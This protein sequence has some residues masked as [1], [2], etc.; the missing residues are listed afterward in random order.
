VEARVLGYGLHRAGHLGLRALRASGGRSPRPDLPFYEICVP[1]PLTAVAWV[2]AEARR[3][4]GRPLRCAGS[5]RAFA[6]AVPSSTTVSSPTP[7][8]CVR[9]VVIR[10]PLPALRPPRATLPALTYPMETQFWR[11]CLSSTL[12]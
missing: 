7:S 6:Q 9:Q 11:P 3:Q 10:L 4:V 2:K 1:A 12:G 8:L 5:P